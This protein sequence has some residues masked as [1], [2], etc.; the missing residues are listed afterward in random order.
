MIVL[1][2]VNSLRGIDLLQDVKSRIL[3]DQIAASGS[4]ESS[5]MDGCKTSGPYGF[6]AGF[7]Q[8]NQCLV[9]KDAMEAVLGFFECGCML[10][11]WNHIITALIPKV[12]NLK[13]MNGFI[14]GMILLS[15]K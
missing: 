12:P 15:K 1:F 10:K 7:Y 6:V 2:W 3:L 4:G 5:Q 14:N 13:K 11:E 9:D 8:Q